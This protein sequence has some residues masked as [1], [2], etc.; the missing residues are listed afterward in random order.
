M[1]IENFP[2]LA[3]MSM[4]AFFVNQVLILQCKLKRVKSCLKDKQTFD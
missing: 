3:S 2:A 4:L 1:V